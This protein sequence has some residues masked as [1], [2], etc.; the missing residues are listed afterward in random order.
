MN[1]LLPLPPSPFYPFQDL[2]NTFWDICFV[3]PKKEEK[4]KKNGMETSF[5]ML[6]SFLYTQ[7]NKNVIRK[8]K[9]CG[10]NNK[11]NLSLVAA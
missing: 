9:N 6:Y 1:F 5:Q 10:L 2:W 8:L 7:L 3:F 11:L 4:H